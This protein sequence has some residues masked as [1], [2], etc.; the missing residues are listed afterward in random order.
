MD[1]VALLAPHA[2]NGS[3]KHPTVLS[4]NDGYLSAR[5]RQLKPV[6]ADTGPLLQGIVQFTGHLWVTVVYDEYLR[7]VLTVAGWTE[8]DADKLVRAQ[9][10]LRGLEVVDGYTRL[11]PPPVNG[12]KRSG[13]VRS[14]DGYFSARARGHVDEEE[15]AFVRLRVESPEVGFR[16]TVIDERGA[17]IAT[18]SGKTDADAWTRVRNEMERQGYEVD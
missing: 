14:D 5:F 8:E 12:S 4:S 17:I 11:R 10:K 13:V 7:E 6:E 16:H 9:L 1:Q 18:S 3:P 15:G 2:T